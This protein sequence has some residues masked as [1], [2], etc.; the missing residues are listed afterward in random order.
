MTVALGTSWLKRGPE[1]CQLAGWAL[2][3]AHV[4]SAHVL[5]A[6]FTKV[7]ESF[8]VQAVHD[9]LYHR[10]QLNSYDH[11]SFPGVVPRTFMGRPLQTEGMS[12]ACKPI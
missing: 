4:I 11:N 7:E 9:I 12:T 1:L 6:P 10:L 5:A 8:G 2:L 3:L